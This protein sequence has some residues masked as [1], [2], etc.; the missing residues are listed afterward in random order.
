MNNFEVN[1]SGSYVVLN[2]KC[3]VN[4]GQEVLLSFP[5]STNFICQGFTYICVLIFAL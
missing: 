3:M 1:D 2:E 4:S 5:G